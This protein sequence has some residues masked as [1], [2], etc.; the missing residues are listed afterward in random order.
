MSLT[1]ET[2]D[3]ASLLEVPAKPKWVGV[4]AWRD[5]QHIFKLSFSQPE[6]FIPLFIYNYYHLFIF[7]Y[8][9]FIPLDFFIPFIPIFPALVLFFKWLDL[10]PFWSRRTY[11]CLEDCTV[12]RLYF[13]VV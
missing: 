10:T 13:I 8:F 12:V 9:V 6:I 3:R 7:Y 4:G 5:L 11:L 2:R 1:V